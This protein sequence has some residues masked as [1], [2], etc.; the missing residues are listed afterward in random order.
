MLKQFLDKIRSFKDDTRNCTVGIVG[1]GYVGLPLALRFLDENFPIICFDIDSKKI[2]SLKEGKSYIKHISDDRIFQMAT[3][4][5][6]VFTN[7]PSALANADV[8]I[9]CVPTPLTRNKEP[10]LEPI[11]NAMG[12]IIPYIRE[13]QLIVLESTT[14]PGTTEEILKPYIE[15]FRS[16][17]KFKVGENIFLAFS[18]EREDPGNSFFNTKNTPKI[19]GGCTPSCLNAATELYDAIIDTVVPV[20]SAKIAEMSKILE[21]TYRFVNI[22]FMNEMK[23]ICERMG[24]DIYEVIEAASSK[25]FG[26]IPFYPCG[27]VGGHCLPLDP[28][29]LRFKAREY[30]IPTKFIELAGEINDYMP[31]YVVDRITEALNEKSCAV[32][33]SEILLLGVAYK[34]NIDD[35]RE[36]AAI[37]I[38]NLLLKKGAS[39]SYSDPH[40]PEF[41]GKSSFPLSKTL[42]PHFDC[43]VIITDHDDFDY[44]LIEKNSPL[45]VD[46]RGRF[47]PNGFNIFR[48]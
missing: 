12:S 7:K 34:K 14:Y 15:E 39:V 16:M 1:L 6:S 27:G 5:H 29:Y 33:G 46:T 35:Y 44:E 17:A 40:I 8:I 26:F 31:E 24:M 18:P 47:A 22:S 36:S 10:D 13:G 9:L 19:V 3:N 48:A 42:K 23:L 4:E 2:E 25:P 38:W 21:N 43:V 41:L 20:K 30:N 32:K 45:I 11:L 37:E 28:F